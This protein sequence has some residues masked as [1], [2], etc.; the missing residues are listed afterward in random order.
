MHNQQTA[1]L[2]FLPDCSFSCF[3]GNSSFLG[4][5]YQ[6][7][8]L[9]MSAVFQVLTPTAIRI[10]ADVMLLI[11]DDS[12]NILFNSL[13]GQA[14]V[15]HLH[16]HC[17]YWPYES[18]LIYRVSDTYALINSIFSI[19]FRFQRFETLNDLSNVYIIEPPHWICSAF[20]FQLTNMNEYDTYLR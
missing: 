16:M 11:A 12:L 9:S 2:Q 7:S 13:L 15:N 10:A 5:L 6:M 3:V 1:G 14:S 20:A 8:A 4:E 18:D 17:L 19:N